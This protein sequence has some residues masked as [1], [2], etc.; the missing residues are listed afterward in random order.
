MRLYK[1]WQK[2]EKYPLP[3]IKSF[4]YQLFFIK[5]LTFFYFLFDK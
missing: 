5:F 3:G 4:V 2:Y 1:P